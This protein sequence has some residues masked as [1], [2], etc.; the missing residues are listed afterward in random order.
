MPARNLKLTP[1]PMNWI[2]LN[3]RNR[4]EYWLL[5][6]DHFHVDLHPSRKPSRA[7]SPPRFPTPP[8][9]FSH[10]VLLKFPGHADWRRTLEVL[11][12]SKVSLKANL[13]RKSTRLN[14]SHGYISYAVFC[15]KKK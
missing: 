12:S 14:S 9:A 5:K 10:A 6:S 7:A 4:G 3:G 11:K 2:S 8:S 1:G 15:L 13:D